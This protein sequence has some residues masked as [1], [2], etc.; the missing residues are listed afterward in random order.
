MTEGWVME[1]WLDRLRDRLDNLYEGRSRRAVRFRYGLLAFD[2]LTIAVF[3][4]QS[5]MPV[6]PTIL[7]MDVAIALVLI[8]DFLARLL[9]APDRRKYL[10]NPIT[11]ADIV[12][13]F[14]L[15]APLVMENFG[16]LRVLRAL[17]LLRSY[18]VLAD[19]RRDVPFFKRN[20]EVIQAAINLLL[21]LFVVTAIVYVAQ[22]SRNPEINDY[23]DALYFTVTTLTT[24]GFGDVTLVGDDGRILAILIMVLGVGLFLRLV[25][26]CLRPA[27]INHR[28][29]DCGLL[30]HEPDAVHCK[31]CGRVLAIDSDGD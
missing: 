2:L 27:K 14:S 1:G 3:L 16:F 4:V 13:I 28:C 24:T 21:F 6:T 26:T 7:A 5:T 23:L 12:V 20:E 8:V 10:L 15:L 18:R 17:R 31:H 22:H 9:I 29:P 19:L 25:Q 11:I 30:R